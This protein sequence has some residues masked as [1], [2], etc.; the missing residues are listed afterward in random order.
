VENSN[1][2]NK[3]YV[4][5]GST[6]GIG[7]AL[8]E[9]LLRKGASIIGV[10]RSTERCERAKQML[11]D[12][13]PGATLSYCVG[14]L[15]IQAQ[16]REIARDV[17]RVVETWGY[18][19]LDGLI[20]NAGTFTFWQRITSEGFETQWA[21]NHLAPFLLTV[22]LLPLLKRSEKAKIITV[23]SGSHYNTKMR[24][25]DIQLLK[26]YNPLQAYK[27]TKLAN[28][29]FTA[30]LNRRLGPESKVRAFA[31]DPGLVNTGMGEKTGSRVAGWYWSFRRKKGIPAEE[32]A[33]GIAALLLDPSAAERGE[34]YWKHGSPKAPDPQA[35]DPIAGERLW[36]MSAKMCGITGEL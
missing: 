11:M 25:D 26:R 14:D 4:I 10:G 32:S 31:A 21:A 17:E 34:I 36:D 27:Q 8:A 24:W 35:L 3:L 5:T 1:R 2:L 13:V 20:N 7:Y 9:I 6:S 18:G 28:V 16:T 33:A 15:A 23:S 12:Q 30:E 19:G 22:E 29:L